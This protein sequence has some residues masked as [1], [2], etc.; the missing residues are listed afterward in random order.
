[1]NLLFYIKQDVFWNEANDRFSPGGLDL[2]VESSSP[3]LEEPQRG[4]WIWVTTHVPSGYYVVVSKMRVLKVG[5]ASSNQYG[6]YRLLG[7]ED[8][9]VLYDIS[10]QPD[11]QEVIAE[12]SF[13]STPVRPFQMTFMGL[14]HVRRLNTTDHAK[15]E[16]WAT[17]QLTELPR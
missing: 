6:P 4:D 12:L 7:D 3:L 1:M 5:A 15:L 9:T 16:A 2:W 17:Q 14:N 13:G 8:G 10:S 11:L